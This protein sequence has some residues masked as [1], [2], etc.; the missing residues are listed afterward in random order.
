MV[1]TDNFARKDTMINR[2]RRLDE[3][4]LEVKEIWAAVYLPVLSTY[5]NCSC[6]CRSD[7]IF[8]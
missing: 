2:G 4:I 1:E 7:L 3:S 6:F 8:K 5:S